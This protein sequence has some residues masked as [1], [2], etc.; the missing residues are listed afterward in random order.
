MLKLF[1]PSEGNINIKGINN[2][3]GEKKYSFNIQSMNIESNKN[4]IENQN[5]NTVNKSFNSAQVSDDNVQSGDVNNIKN[6]VYI[7][8][9]TM[10]ICV[11]IMILNKKRSVK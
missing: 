5:D 7:L 11:I 9:T 4:N 10:S 6:W 2:F 8:I 3:C 1:I